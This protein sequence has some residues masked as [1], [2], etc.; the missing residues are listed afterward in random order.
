MKTN[1]LTLGLLALTLSLASCGG[2]HTLPVPA[3]GN[4]ATFT[5]TATNSVTAL[6]SWSAVA[7]ASNFTL[8]RK[9]N[10]GAYAPVAASLPANTLSYTDAALTPGTA[11]TYRLKA[12]NGAGSSPGVERDVTTPA[13]GNPD[14]N[15]SVQPGTL[16][17]GAGKSGTVQIEIGRPANPEGTPDLSL[18]GAG[19]GQGTGKIAGTFGGASGTV[20]T[21]TIGADVPVGPHTLTVRGR[22]GAV[23]QT[24][25]L[26]VN[27]ERWLLIDDD[28]SANNWPANNPGAADSAADRFTRAALTAADRTF[29]VWVVP[30]SASGQDRDEPNGPGAQELSRYS[31]VVWYTGNTTVHP[32]TSTDRYELGA[33][34]N[35][36]NRR[37]ILFSPGF[38]R[39]AVTNGATLAAPAA[40]Y[41]PLVTGIMGLEKVAFPGAAAY[42]LT[43]ESGSV[44]GGMTVNVA[45]SV[46][47][48][49]QPG[50]GA[51]ALLREGIHV[52]ASGRAKVG[53]DGSSRVVLAA[54]SLSHV[55][56]GD[57][58]ALLGRLMAF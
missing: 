50:A 35:T 18:E 13:P 1:R 8:E 38:V 27:V 42:A 5:A 22:N 15:L 24:A 14:F 21:L 45:S 36:P 6:L 10:T 52:V 54:L 12:V 31:G 30:Y 17:L 9:T 49:L 57:V 43:G 16:T 55:S 40:A 46:R 47:G 2:G 32:I 34:L 44:A 25:Q 58:A 7:D 39:D 11:Y 23:T 37:V 29:E 56:Q 33:F 19:V 48:F 26:T 3:P 4:P 41:Q 28:R 53:T 51:Q 20:L